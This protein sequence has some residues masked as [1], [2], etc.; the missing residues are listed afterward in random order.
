[1]R[2]FTLLCLGAVLF[3][4]CQKELPA[5][6]PVSG[7]RIVTIA[8]STADNISAL[9]RG[10]LVIGVS[11]WCAVEEFSELPRIG[12]LG[13]PSL[14]RILELN[15]NMVLVQGRQ[16]V[17]QKYCSQNNIFFKSFNTDSIS[18]WRQEIEW[19]G[20]AL[21][22]TEQANHLLNSFDK[23]LDA[24]GNSGEAVDCLLVVGRRNFQ[25]A[26]LLIAGKAS[27]LSELLSAVGG[28]NVVNEES[29]YIFLQ[30]EL[31]PELNPKIIFELHAA[32][33]NASALDIWQDSFSGL[34]AVK[35]HEVHSLFRAQALM[36]SSKMIETARLMSQIIQQQKLV[37]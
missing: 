9:G 19:L 14:E 16:D 22:C 34:D 6:L 15:P 36:P 1:M 26:D 13:S 3:T 32:E 5:P 25:V 18:D 37:Q 24:L 30:E 17:L 35:G 27:F 31:L 12:G 7:W 4:A 20:Q 23:S 29:N 8:P 11:E 28:R 33:E 21:Q 2:I 10:E